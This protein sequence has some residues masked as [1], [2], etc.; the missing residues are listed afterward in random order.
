MKYTIIALTFVSLIFTLSG[1]QDRYRYPC[2]DP[3]NWETPRC[4][5]PQCDITKDC[6]EHIFKEKEC[7]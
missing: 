2:Q 1:C 7:K 4:K 6:P 3:N 5:K